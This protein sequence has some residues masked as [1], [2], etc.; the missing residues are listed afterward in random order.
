VQETFVFHCCDYII[1]R[2]TQL[3]E[4]LLSKYQAFR[5]ETAVSNK[6]PGISHIF[7][8]SFHTRIQETWYFEFL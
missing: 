4:I 1:C 6:I 2:S 7:R 5:Q 8:S 3:D